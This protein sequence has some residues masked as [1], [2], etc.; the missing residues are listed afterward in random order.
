MKKFILPV[1]LFIGIS[2]FSQ[3][4]VLTVIGNNNGVPAQLTFA[5]LQ[6]VFKGNQAKWSNGQKVVIALMKVATGAG[7]TTCSKVYNMSP[8]EATKFWLAL[9]IKGTIDA[10][11]FFNTAGELQ[12]FVSG[13]SGAIG[14]M[15][16]AVKAPNTK[17]VLI[18]GKTSF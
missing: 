18:D 14:I 5:G 8:S 6:S 1:L 9:S 11:V 16:G 3:N 4:S 7:A 2:S 15:E 10:P 12:S 13:T 17:T